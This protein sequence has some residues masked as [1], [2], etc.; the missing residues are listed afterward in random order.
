MAIDPEFG[1]RLRTLKR[2][3]EERHDAKL[4]NQE[5]AERVRL[6]AGVESLTGQA[7]GQ[8]VNAGQ[9]PS[10]FVLLRALA[11]VLETTVARLVGE[12]ETPG[13]T[14]PVSAFK[15]ASAKEEAATKKR[16]A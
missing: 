7:V 1:R 3:W 2:E 12:N 16:R 15:K 14:A 4:T 11:V 10:S 5:L 9:E 8:W 13:K 6:E